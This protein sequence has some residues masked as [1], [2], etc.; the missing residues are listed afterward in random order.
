MFLAV[1]P[2]PAGYG[3]IGL[4]LSFMA[5]PDVATP[6]VLVAS[7]RNLVIAIAMLVVATGLVLT[8]QLTLWLV[9]LP[10]SPDLAFLGVLL[11]AA[12]LL[13]APLALRD[14]SEPQYRADPRKPVAG[15][16]NLMLA[17]TG[18]VAFTF[19]YTSG[20]TWIA[21]AL[22]ALVLPL[23]LGASRIRRARQGLVESR[24]ARRLLDRQLRGHLLQA[25]NHVVLWGLVVATVPVGTFELLGG[26]LDDTAYIVVLSLLVL[27]ALTMAMLSLFPL[28]RVHVATNALVLVGSV[29][30]TAQLATVLL[31]PTSPVTI[32]SPLSGTWFVAHGGHAELVNYHHIAYGQQDA[33]DIVQV[34][35]GSTHR[36]DGADLADY[37]AF[38]Q[39]L[40]A[41]AD[42]V[43]TAAED[44]LRD[45]PVG[46][47]NIE[48]PE[49]NHVIVDIG[50]GRH[51]VMAHVRRGTLRVGVGDRVR[52]GQVLAQVGNSGNTDEPHL[53]LQVQNLPELDASH[54]APGLHTSPILFRDMIITRGGWTDLVQEADVR[55]G[56][57]F[58]STERPE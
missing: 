46:S 48:H 9:A 51:V 42:G 44:G 29:F 40:L 8:P 47:V 34:R 7:R 5:A 52:A 19:A 14:A 54:P 6:R 55:R 39:P 16:R 45:E 21:L 15:K 28:R 13:A 4:A 25:V 37:Y 23:A 18:L 17:L 36:G 33:F 58:R 27:G 56:D 43:V 11:L 10:G 35:G 57:Y 50:A 24:F 30:L 20:M 12:L 1:V 32:S 22:S 41:P 38:G 3:V 49:G 31:P 53:H 2:P 26:E